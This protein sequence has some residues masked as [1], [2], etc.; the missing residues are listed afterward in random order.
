[1]KCGRP[2]PRG[3]HTAYEGPS[4]PRLLSIATPRANR[5]KFCHRTV[6]G[7]LQ[8]DYILHQWLPE[9]LLRKSQKCGDDPR[10]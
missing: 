6:A 2:A 1:M 4:Y 8:V 5:I 9:G 7:Y 3:D 10:L